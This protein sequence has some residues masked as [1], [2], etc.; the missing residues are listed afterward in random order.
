M[1][2]REATDP[3]VWKKLSIRWQL[4]ALL[5]LFLSAIQVLSLFA[6]YYSDVQLRKELAV[7]QSKTLNIALQSDML[8]AIVASDMELLSDISSRIEGFRAV[9]YLSLS[10]GDRQIFQ[11][12]REGSEIPTH[13]IQS[14]VNY[15]EPLFLDD[16]LIMRSAVRQ[17]GFEYGQVQTYFDLSSYH[18]GIRETL[19]QTLTRFIVALTLAIAVALWL[20]RRF[21]EPFTRLADAMSEVD[22]ESADFPSVSVDTENEI[23]ILYDGYNELTRKVGLSTQRLRYL[24]EHDNLTGLLNRYAIEK[25][26]EKCL[27]SNSGGTNTLA[28]VGIDQFE[29]IN[30]SAGSDTGDKLLKQVGLIIGSNVHDNT[31]IARRGGGNFIIL[32]ADQTPQAAQK[33]CLDVQRALN[34]YRITSSNQTYEISVSIGLVQFKL[35]EYDSQQLFQAA[36]SAFHAAR[37]QGPGQISHYNREQPLTLQYSQDLK[38]VSLLRDAL[39]PHTD[40]GVH[41]ALYAQEIVPLQQQTDQ[42]SYEILI[43]LRDSKGQMIYPNA[44]L[45]TASRFSLMT[46]ID[47]YVLK[48][49][50]KLVCANQ[51]HL[52][53]L[54]FVNIN[55]AGLTLKSEVFQNYL[56]SAIETVNFPWEKLVLEVTETSAVGDLAQV[57]S[58]IKFCRSHGIRIALDD[59]GTGMSSFE[60][61]KHL[62]LDIVK[63]D[64]SF[65]RDMLSDSVDFA[66]VKYVNEICKLRGQE[67]VAEFIETEEH[68]ASVRAIGYDYGQGYFFGRPIALTALMGR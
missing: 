23:R 13:L 16:L 32:F 33:Q 21:T 12:A 68:A 54:A 27:S 35:G 1:K 49:Y 31:R 19:L 28:L 63:I 25:E 14:A 56:V 61:L 46:S 9:R 22:I 11:Y 62:P 55:L 10:V 43:R 44:F 50:F 4:V 29:L 7:E 37:E 15:D 47:I 45:G 64:G 34:R 67:T 58:F 26:V 66:T 57:S 18:T 36:D 51:K 59:F 40:N 41:F 5:V 2:L 60:Y 48:S 6:T 8:R 39:I 65:V 53:Q 17:D 30:D 38:V 3:T 52:D 24:S 20:G 42:V